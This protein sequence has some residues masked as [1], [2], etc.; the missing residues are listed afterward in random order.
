MDRTVEALL[1]EAAQHRIRVEFE[2]SPASH[3][4]ELR[5][6]FGRVV[7]VT[8]LCVD[9]VQE[10]LAAALRDET[11]RLLADLARRELKT[12][13]MF[14]ERVFD[15]SPS[16]SPDTGQVYA[17]AER[18]FLIVRGAEQLV[19]F[20]SERARFFVQNQYPDAFE[21]EDGSRF[22]CDSVRVN[23]LSDNWVEVVVQY[24][25]VAEGQR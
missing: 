23:R 25:A 22:N 24:D 16:P 9:D 12:N 4:L 11:E 7:L 1:L 2:Y 15:M 3:A 21:A 10:T 6:Q 8:G 17:H 14:P 18:R 5:L 19:R 13:G 20:P